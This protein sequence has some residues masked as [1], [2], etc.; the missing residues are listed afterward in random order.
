MSR[1]KPVRARD[2]AAASGPRM[3]QISTAETRKDTASTSTER[4]GP[5]APTRSA[6]ALMPALSVTEDAAP[7]FE[8]AS[9]S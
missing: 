5:T 3:R 7:I 2:A 9:W 1:A 6:P 8:F 4:A